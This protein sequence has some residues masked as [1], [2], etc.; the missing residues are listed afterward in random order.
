MTS[1]RP[2]CREKADN[3]SIVIDPK[4]DLAKV[5]E[6]RSRQ[7]FTHASVTPPLANNGCDGRVVGWFYM[8]KVN[9]CHCI[10]FVAYRAA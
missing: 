1:G 10:T 8:A 4:A 9:T 7:H 3:V 5:N 2:V 6:E